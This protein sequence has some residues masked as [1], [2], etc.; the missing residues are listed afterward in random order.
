MEIVNR[1]VA[2]EDVPGLFEQADMVV[3]PYTSASQSGVL[4]IAAAFSLLVVASRVGGL[5]EQVTDGQSGLL[6]EPDSAAAL[7]AAIERLLGDPRLAARL[8]EAL[9][10]EFEEQRSWEKAAERLLEAIS[11]LGPAG[12]EKIQV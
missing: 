9:Q 6:V 5:P 12:N 2:D 1:W 10:R 4:A 3:L 8:G 7:A 11:G